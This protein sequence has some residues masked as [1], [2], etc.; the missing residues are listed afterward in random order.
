MDKGLAASYDRLERKLIESVDTMIK[1]EKSTQNGSRAAVKPF[2]SDCRGSRP[3]C[4]TGYR[5]TGHGRGRNG[6]PRAAPA[7]L[8]QRNWRSVALIG[9]ATGKQV[10]GSTNREVDGFW[11][12]SDRD[13]A[14]G[15]DP[16]GTVLGRAVP[17]ASM[18][19]THK[20]SRVLSFG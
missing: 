8:E 9:Y 5:S 19:T 15:M 4:E 11:R 16:D 14:H 6:S 13:K 3:L 1:S 18:P 17:P 12:A 7:R 10:E 2:N 20:N